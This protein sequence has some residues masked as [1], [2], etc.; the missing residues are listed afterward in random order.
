M[1][2][3]VDRATLA[4]SQRPP[5][6][7]APA[8]QPQL[9]TEPPHQSRVVRW[10][11]ALVLAIAAIFAWEQF[12]KYESPGSA[13]RAGAAPPQ[14]IR[15]GAIVSGDMPLYINALG[16][17]TPLAT[18]T[19]R[20]QVNGQLQQIGFKEGQLVKEGDFLA[21]IDPRP[22]QATLAQYQAQQAKDTALYNQAQSDLQ[23]YQTLSKQDSIAT[24][25]VAD[26][27]FLVKQDKAAMES[28]Q[29]QIDSANLNIVYAHI[30]SPVTGRVGL[31][32]VDQGNF[33]QMTDANGIVVVTQLEPIS[34]LFSVPEDNLPQI[35]AR[36]KTGATLPV[37]VFDRANVTQLATGSLD[38]VDNQIDATTGTVKIR[39]KFDNTDDILFPQQF[40][41]VRLL[42]DTMKDAVIAPSAAVQQGSKGPFVYIVNDDETVSVRQVKTGP[43]ERE[44]T[45]IL[46]GLKVGEKVVIDGVDRLRDGAKVQVR[47]NL[48]PQAGADSD[49]PSH[50]GRGQGGGQRGRR[51][52]QNQ[53]DG[54]PAPAS[55]DPQGQ[56]SPSQGSSSQARSDPSH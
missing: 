5:T 20:S 48:A 23:R 31:R 1:D 30:V 32:Q 6:P 45:A 44:R 35:F 7:D 28:D 14:T 52:G 37:V 39:A 12:Q 34:V 29:A 42:V 56:A 26:Q 36:L 16:A 25:Q 24:Q 22:F 3:T 41:N 50:E 21:Q 15:D 9:Q 47:N 43:V 18:V 40:V 38:A 33:I 53:G 8:P 4:L 17:V 11:V 49:A 46:A 27:E 55:S 51:Q 54:A 19:V 10:L 2:D 13:N